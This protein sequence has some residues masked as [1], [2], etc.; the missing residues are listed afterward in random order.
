MNWYEI[1]TQ[2]QQQKKK[3]SLNLIS[4]RGGNGGSGEFALEDGYFL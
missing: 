4:D 1:T 3:N 2:Q